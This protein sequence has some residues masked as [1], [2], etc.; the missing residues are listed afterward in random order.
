[1]HIPKTDLIALKRRPLPL[2][3]DGRGRV[4]G[5]AA[6]TATMALEVVSYP[7][8]GDNGGEPEDCG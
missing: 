7:C 1:M 5:L 6:A 4:R 3:L 2:P 8:G